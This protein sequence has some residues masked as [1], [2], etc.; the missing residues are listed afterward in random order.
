MIVSL[1]RSKI[2]GAAVNVGWIDWVDFFTSCW[3]PCLVITSVQPWSTVASRWAPK[4]NGGLIMCWVE[5]GVRNQS[6]VVIECGRC[7]RGLL[8]L[9]L[10]NINPA[11]APITR[12]KI[13]P[14]AATGEIGDSETGGRTI[15]LSVAPHVI[16]AKDRMAVGAVNKTLVLCRF[17]SGGCWD[18]P[19]CLII[20]ARAV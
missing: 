9:Y 6:E 5:I 3:A 18:M 10:A 19:S 20:V 16:A 8:L 7:G 17:N 12:A 11:S 13:G 4:C 1:I 15:Q 14:L 2:V